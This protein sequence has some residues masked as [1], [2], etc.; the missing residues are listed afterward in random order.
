[1]VRCSCGVRVFLTLDSFS[2]VWAAFTLNV[3]IDAL[4]N[5]SVHR[6]EQHASG[7]KTIP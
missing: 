6:K 1:M 7:I 4:Y 3:H 2:S 5:E